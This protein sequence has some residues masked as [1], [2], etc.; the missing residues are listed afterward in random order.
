MNI[1]LRFLSFILLR[2]RVN[3][4]EALSCENPKLGTSSLN[5]FNRSL[6]A[7]GSNNSLFLMKYSKLSPSLVLDV[8]FQ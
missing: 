3:A 4:S 2:S 1:L 6:D 7:M 5:E 8:G